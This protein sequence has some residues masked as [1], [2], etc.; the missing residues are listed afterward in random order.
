M[1]E[2]LKTISRIANAIIAIPA[3][4]EANT[5]QIEKQNR[6]IE[7]QNRQIEEQLSSA[8]FERIVRAL[9]RANKSLRSFKFAMLY[10]DGFLY[11]RNRH[12]NIMILN[13]KVEPYSASLNHMGRTI[14]IQAKTTEEMIFMIHQEI[15]HAEEDARLAYHRSQR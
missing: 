4:I 12:A 9:D 10:R 8:G 5:R 15:W 3:A 7:E 14:D 6:Q 2:I 13:M 1:R 11:V